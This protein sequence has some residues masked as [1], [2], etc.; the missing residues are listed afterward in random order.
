[1]AGIAFSQAGLGLC[2]GLAHVLGG[3]FHL[4]HGRLNGILLPEVV[5]CNGDGCREKYADLARSAGLGGGA[6]T[7]AVRNLKNGLIRLRRQ[8][9]LPESLAQAGVDPR[10]VRKQAGRIA[11]MTLADPCCKTNPV[12]VDAQVVCKVLEAVTGRG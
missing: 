2:H 9:Q 12:Q 6:D 3:M 5:S 8:L 7:L 1:M 10:L 4:P 11:E